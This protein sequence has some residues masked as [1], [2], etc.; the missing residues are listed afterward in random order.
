MTLNEYLGAIFR[1]W[2]VIAVCAVLGGVLGYAYAKSQP[3]VYQ[4]AASVMVVPEQGQNSSELV[5]GSNYVQNLVAS[6][7]VLARSPYVLDPVIDRL[8]LDVTPVSLGNRVA[9][10]NPLNTVV[11]TVSVQDGSPAQAQEIANE[12]TRQLASA[13]PQLS[14][15]LED[16]SPAVRVTT[17]AEAGLPVHPIAPNTRLLAALGLA[18]GAAMGFAYAVVRVLLARRV[19]SWA[20]LQGLSDVPLLGQVVRAPR[21]RTLPAAVLASP[22]AP[23]A[24]SLRTVLANLRFADLDN[25]HRVLMVSSG[26]PMEGK[27]SV[28]TGLALALAEEG[29]RVLLVDADLRRPSIATL[30]GLEGAAGLTNLLLGDVDL[31]NVVQGWGHETLDVLPSGVVP[32]NPGALLASG[33][34]AKVM[35]DLRKAYEFVVVDSAP[36]LPLSDPLLLAQHV[37]GVIVVARAGKT[38]LTRL[39]ET[40]EGFRRSGAEVLGVALNGVRPI[41][42]GRRSDYFQKEP[43]AH[44]RRPGRR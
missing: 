13:V 3:P 17:I 5:Q 31:E 12:I 9:V 2:A 44:L 20:S 23:P 1:H 27:S 21:G 10:D 39:K 11:I 40:L 42:P 33:R 28:A 22:G 4:A 36:L 24:E 26:N 18:L 7:A 8:E 15:E 34:L 37:D 19:T 14:P 6:Y 38:R 43:A 25:D 16:S 30:T 35:V 41:R 29:T 32:P